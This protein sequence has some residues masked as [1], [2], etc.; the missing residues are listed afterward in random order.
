MET[1]KYLCEFF[2][3]NF[4]HWLGGL[5]YLAVIFSTPLVWV[6]KNQKDKEDKQ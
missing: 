3:G 1:V 2:F 6:V 5:F 4:C